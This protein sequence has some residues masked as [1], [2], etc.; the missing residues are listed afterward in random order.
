MPTFKIVVR[1][2][3]MKSDG[4]VNVKI[5]VCHN[6]KTRYIRT[7]YFV[8]PKE[9]YFDSKEGLIKIG[10]SFDKEAADRANNDLLIQRAVMAD[11]A[12]KQKNINRMDIKALLRIFRDKHRE[13]DFYAVIDDLIQQKKKDGNLNYSDSFRATRDLV[14]KSTGKSILYFEAIDYGWLERL[15]RS[16]RDKGLSE[17]S[18]GIFMRNIRT[19]WNEGRKRKYVDISFYPF[20]DY[21]I[22][23]GNPR[24][25]M[26]LTPEEMATIAKTEIKKPMMCWA[27]D[28][29]MLSFCLIGMNPKDIFLVKEISNGRI[30]YIRSKGKRKYSIKVPPHALHII[31]RYKGQDYLLNTMDKYNDYRSAVKGIDRQLK[32]ITKLCRIEKK[33]SLYTFR[34][35]WSAYARFLGISKDDIAAALGHKDIDLPRVTEFYD[36]IAEEQRRVDIAN[37]K[38][39]RLILST[40]PKIK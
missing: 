25:N 11:K 17:T 38:V 10:G 8:I 29:A 12:R 13:L 36:D 28:M 20:R 32:D 27:R 5:R 30:T 26:I 24:L 14:R 4:T 34:H 18:I 19:V 2:K 15:D 33:V 3:E 21:Q 31:N 6:K 40:Q 7:G 23:R 22:P 16:W 35:S 37:K 39:I 9:K 1:K